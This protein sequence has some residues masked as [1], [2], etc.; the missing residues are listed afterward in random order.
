MM[1]IE[2]MYICRKDSRKHK[3]T[4]NVPSHYQAVSQTVFQTLLEHP[5]D[6]D[7]KKTVDWVTDQATISATP[8]PSSSAHVAASNKSW[9]ERLDSPT[10]HPSYQPLG[11]SL[12]SHLL[13][14][15]YSPLLLP[16][17]L[18]VISMP[19]PYNQLEGYIGYV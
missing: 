10:F 2:K 18:P 6:S 9:R 12:P 1:E 4:I 19:S 14:F 13:Y 8:S 17:S 3:Y 16:L 11:L 5:V 15:T 7:C